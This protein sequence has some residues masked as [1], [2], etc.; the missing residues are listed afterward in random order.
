MDDGSGKWFEGVVESYHGSLQN[1]LRIASLRTLVEVDSRDG[2][3][4]LRES[5]ENHIPVYACTLAHVV[6]GVAPKWT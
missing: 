4:R 6:A 1:P 5:K 2:A 3:S